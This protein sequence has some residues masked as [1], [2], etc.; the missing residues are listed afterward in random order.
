[1][2]PEVVSTVADVVRALVAVLTYLGTRRAMR[3]G[4]P[5]RLPDQ[6]AD[7]PQH[8]NMAF[9]TIVPAQRR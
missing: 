7:D 4:G 6:G 8:R 5:V 3:A 2:H 9:P 1:M